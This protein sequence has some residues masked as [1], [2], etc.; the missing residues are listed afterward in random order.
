[1]GTNCS[2]RN[3]RAPHIKSRVKV[4]KLAASRRVRDMKTLTENDAIYG[5]D[6]AATV[7]M[8]TRTEKDG[9]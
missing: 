4:Q 3:Y 2:E 8:E 9:A 6:G 1:L 5:T 7:S